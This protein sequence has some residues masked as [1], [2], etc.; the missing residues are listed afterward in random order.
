MVRTPAFGRATPPRIVSLKCEVRSLPHSVGLADLQRP[1]IRAD[2]RLRTTTFAIPIAAEAFV[3]SR[4]SSVESRAVQSKVRVANRE[5]RVGPSA[6]AGSRYRLRTV[7]SALTC[8][9]DLRLGLATDSEFRP[10]TFDER[11]SAAEQIHNRARGL[12]ADAVGIAAH[13]RLR[14]RVCKKASSATGDG[15]RATAVVVLL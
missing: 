8:G 4:K 12:P 13:F 14:L 15:S 7:L 9:S 10:A 5:F 6:Y 11:L 2:F 1:S 3:A